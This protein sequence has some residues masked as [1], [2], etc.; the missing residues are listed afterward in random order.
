MPAIPTLA[1][2]EILGGGG[3]STWSPFT[4]TKAV[5]VEGLETKPGCTLG[6]ANWWCCTMRY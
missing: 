4:I 1:H 5:L 2:Y 3:G 6:A